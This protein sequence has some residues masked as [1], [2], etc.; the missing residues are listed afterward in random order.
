M[1]VVLVGSNGFVGSAFGRLLSARGHEVISVTRATYAA[2]IGVSADVVIEAACNSKK[3]FAEEEPF[4]EFDASV[5]HR[6]RTLRDFPAP[7]HLHISSVDVYV[8]LTSPATTGED[9]PIVPEAASY[10]GLHKRM[11]EELVQKYADEWLIIR[12]A[13]MVGPGLR[14]NPVHDIINGQPLRIH[15]ESRYQ[16]LHTDDAARISWDLL[17]SGA[18]GEIYNLCGAG[19]IRPV[20]IAQLA[21]RPLDLSQLPPDATPRVVDINIEKIQRRYSIAE[22]AATVDA[23]ISRPG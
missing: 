4:L 20:D 16:F 22:S 11:S 19:T 6:L 12:L 21:S 3:F 10:Y 14:K 5:G 1:K 17:E 8:D 15:P 18:R 7:V 9:V 23:F 13:G 2:A